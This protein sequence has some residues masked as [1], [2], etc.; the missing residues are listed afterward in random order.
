[1]LYGNTTYFNLQPKTEFVVSLD[2][3]LFSLN[4]N[5]GK[6][7]QSGSYAYMVKPGM[8][9]TSDADACQKAIPVNI[10]SN[11]TGIQAVEHAGLKLVEVIFYNAGTLKMPN[12][13]ALMVDAPCA[14]LWNMAKNTIHVAN[15]LC[16][17]ANPATIALTLINNKQEISLK[18]NLPDKEFSGKSVSLKVK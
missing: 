5:H 16:E 3:A 8:N 13:D 9:K 4:I 15:P 1:M 12:G 7:P 11:T 17:S 2:T 14:V 6:N 10:L 18:A